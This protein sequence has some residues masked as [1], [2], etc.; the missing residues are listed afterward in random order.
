MQK[1]RQLNDLTNNSAGRSIN[2][3]EWQQAIVETKRQYE[4]I[5]RALEVNFSHKN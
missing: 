5:D 1:D 3:N 2:L 4:A